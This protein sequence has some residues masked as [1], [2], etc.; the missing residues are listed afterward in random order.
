MLG[1]YI[2]FVLR[3]RLA[4]VLVTLGVTALSLYSISHGVV[5]SSVEKL[6][7]GDSPAY[8]AYL[9]RVEVF[10]NDEILVVGFEDPSVLEPAAQERLRAAIERIEALP[11]VARVE[12][13][14]SIQR[15]LSDGGFIDVRRLA[16]EPTDTPEEVA[17]LWEALQAE[18]FASGLVVGPTGFASAI[19][20]ELTKDP[21]RPAEG[22]PA[23]VSEVV[24]ILEEAGWPAE[25]THRAGLQATVAE[26]VLQSELNLT[27]LFPVVAVA[28]LLTVWLLFRRVWPAAIALGVSLLGVI[29]TMGFSVFLDREISILNAIVPAVILVV[30]FSDVVHL[31]SAYLLGLDSGASKNEAVMSSALEVGKACVMTSV[32][33][34]VGFVSLSLIPTPA[35]RVMGLVLGFGVAVSLL[36]AV[37]LVPIL[38]DVLP[39]PRSLR[40]GATAGVQ[41]ILDRVLALAETVGTQRPWAVII[42]FGSLVAVSFVGISRLVVETD[43]ARR[44]DP[45]N[46]VRV[47]Q[48]WFATRFDGTN[49]LSVYVETN[50]AEGVLDADTFARIAAFQDAVE[51]MPEVDDALSLV[52]LMGRMHVALTGGEA[53]GAG[54]LPTTRGAVAKYLVLFEMAGGEE[55]DRLIDFERRVMRITVRLKG[56]RF[57]DTSAVGARIEALGN[58]MLGDRGSV[59]TTGLLFLLGGWIDQVL[60]GQKRALGVSFLVIALMMVLGLRSL[61]VGLWS[62]VPNLLPLFLLGGWLGFVWDDVDSDALIQ[63]LFALGIGVDDTIHFM[64]R[65]RIEA[66]RTPDVRTALARTFSFAGRAIVMTTVILVVGF[67][68]FAVSDYLTVR[69]MGTLLPLCLVLALLAD[70][71]LVPAMV[72]V[73]WMRFRSDKR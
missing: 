16:D 32:T 73:G 11:M 23:L 51:A 49:V 69:M 45:S 37:T 62:M 14:L 56:E 33:T 65:Y 66:A 1:R 64:M 38:F 15:I 5:A 4:V 24:R 6:F 31:C 52:D 34:F 72:Q 2:R 7:L 48:D 71:L 3:N 36:M 59:D 25:M 39:V 54:P 18:P 8:R 42:L 50:E 12:S 53:E 21:H 67:L 63:A 22:G 13:V 27:R 10:G 28:L 58:E 20:V 17:A 55:T 47:D 46:P 30:A 57:R 68:P 29:W 26:V 40:S 61:R 70:V 60:D 41:R 35:F 19:I 43:F 9:D 44:L